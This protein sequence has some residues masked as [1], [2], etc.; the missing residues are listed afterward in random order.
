M[1][2]DQTDN[3]P[4]IV[5]FLFA[6]GIASIPYNLIIPGEDGKPAIGIDG[7]IKSGAPFIRAVELAS[8]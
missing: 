5:N 6:Y 2:A 4:V 8:Q 3:D 1:V 7:P